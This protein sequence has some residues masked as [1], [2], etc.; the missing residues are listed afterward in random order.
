MSAPLAIILAAGKGTRMDNNLPKVLCRVCGRAMIDFVLDA[1]EGAGVKR[2]LVVVGYRADDVRRELSSREGV[3]FIEQIEQ[4][5]TGHAVAVCRSNI[6][7]HDGAVVILAGDSP[8]VRSESLS[9]LLGQFSASRP[10]CILGTVISSNPQGLGRIVRDDNGGF[11]GIVEERDASTE[12]KQIQEVNMSTYVF[13]CRD[14]L[15]ALERMSDNNKQGEYYLT[16]CPGILKAHGLDVQAHAVLHPS[17]ALSINTVDE[18]AA[19][20][21]QM[22]RLGNPCAN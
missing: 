6:E 20:E 22:R 15:F 7:Q 3:E 21:A 11:L 19:A 13:N 18:L 16:D 2:F 14:L 5:G 10:A 9:K 1:L 12:Q 8:L 4:L 17:E